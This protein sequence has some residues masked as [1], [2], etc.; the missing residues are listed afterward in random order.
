MV[1]DG[2][3]RVLGDVCDRDDHGDE[4]DAVAVGWAAGSWLNSPGVM[5]IKGTANERNRNH[6]Q[7]TGWS[8]PG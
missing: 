7:L 2:C 5:L 8:L 3:F 1:L 6:V 4:D